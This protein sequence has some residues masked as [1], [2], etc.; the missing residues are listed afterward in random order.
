MASLRLSLTSDLRIE[1]TEAAIFNHPSN[2]VI[3]LFIEIVLFIGDIFR[4]PSCGIFPYVSNNS[5]CYQF[6]D[7]SF[8][9]FRLTSK[10]L[11]VLVIF[12]SLAVMKILRVFRPPSLLSE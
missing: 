6:F 9:L 11:E 12:S 10:Y 5:S 1:P 3:V 4:T 8:N 2:K 7:Y